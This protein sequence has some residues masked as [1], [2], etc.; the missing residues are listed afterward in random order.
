MRAK[1]NSFNIS[2]RPDTPYHVFISTLLVIHKMGGTIRLIPSL[3]RYIVRTSFWQTGQQEKF[4]FLTSHPFDN[5]AGDEGFINGFNIQ[6]FP[7]F[8]SPPTRVLDGRK[9]YYCWIRKGRLNSRR[10]LAKQTQPHKGGGER[11]NKIEKSAR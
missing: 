4:F 8:T 1:R 3:D 7:D 2:F 11:K 10:G 5:P 6:V 9:S